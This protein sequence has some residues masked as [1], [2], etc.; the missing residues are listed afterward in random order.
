ML[1]G[2]HRHRSRRS[3]PR[4]GLLGLGAGGGFLAG[5][6]I[7]AVTIAV[8]V[9]VAQVAGGQ[10]CAAV[11]AG[12]AAVVSGGSAGGT[13][14]QI[15]THYV[16]QGL[17][18]CSYPSPPSDG[19]Y[20]ALPPTDYASAAACGGYLEVTGPHG[21]VRVKVIDQCPDCAAGHIDLSEA[22]FAALAPLSAGL[23]SV[24]YSSLAAPPLPGPVSVEVKQGSSQYWLALLADNT[25]NPLAAVQVRTSSGWLSLARASY[26]YWIA[27]SGA[28][29][30]PFTVRLTDIE[31]HQVTVS[32]ITLSPGT[33]QSTGTWMYGG[34]TTTTPSDSAPSLAATSAAPATSAPR[35]AATA[36]AS[37]TWSASPGRPAAPDSRS[38]TLPASSTRTTLSPTAPARSSC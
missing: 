27:S 11:V 12:G 30:G 15:A 8:A 33:V 23:I 1:P 35:T 14:S 36:A 9:G 13:G 16:L 10:A 5:A 28:G 7:A 26:D 18:N 6:A 3:R 2:Q 25:G 34:G 24:S 19:L 17:P 38:R 37:A 32:G 29:A 22:A 21:S 20:V 31:G 4:F